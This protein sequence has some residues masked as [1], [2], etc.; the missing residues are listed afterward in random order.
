MTVLYD[1]TW[2]DVHDI[3]LNEKAGFKLTSAV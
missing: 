1:L 2:K 3:L